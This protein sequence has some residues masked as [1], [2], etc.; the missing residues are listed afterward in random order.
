MLGLQAIDINVAPEFNAQGSD[1][2]TSER[3]NAEKIIKASPV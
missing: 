1:H 2:Q 3:K